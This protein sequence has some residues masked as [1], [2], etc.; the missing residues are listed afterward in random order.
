[1]PPSQT[2]HPRPA[3]PKYGRPFD[4]WNSVSAGHQRAESK[5][6]HGWRASRA[7]KLHSQF[8]AGG[9]GSDDFDARRGVLAPPAARARVAHS[10]ADMLRQP[11]TMR[12]VAT[13]VGGGGQGDAGLV[14]E[15]MGMGVGVG[16]AEKTQTA[17]ARDQKAGDSR[18]MFD[19][20]CIY[21]N[22]STHPLVSDHKLKLLLAEHGARMALH[23]GRRQVTHVILGKPSSALGGGGG[24]GGGLAGGK[25]EREIRKTRGCGVKFVGVEWYV[26]SFLIYPLPSRPPLSS[27]HHACRVLESIKAGKRLP[28]A[29]F[30]GV[31][32]AAHGQQS[33]LRAFS[34]A[35]GKVGST[36][37][38]SGSAQGS[39]SC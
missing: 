14:R 1:M 7:R 37:A 22:G 23:L 31:K 13:P 3:E 5:G 19:G 34:N 33:L 17:E 11:G 27:S 12:M 6:P 21:V 30:S 29:R 9:A 25:L 20:L 15:G 24:A 18:K 39:K 16:V 8:A 28:E 26:R 2:P 36:Q 10:V 38:A 35:P 4:P 32:L